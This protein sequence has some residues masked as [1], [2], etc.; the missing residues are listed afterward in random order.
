MRRRTKYSPDF[1]LS[2]VKEYLSDDSLT[3]ADICE[4][5]SISRSAFLKW[6]KKY[7][8]SGFD[9][10]VFN[11]KKGRPK[12]IISDFSKIPPFIYESAGISKSNSFDSDDSV[13]LKKKIEYYERLILEKEVL[14]KI[15]EDEINFLKKKKQFEKVTFIGHFLL[16]FKYRSYGVSLSFLLNHYSISSSSFYYNNRLFFVIGKSKR[17]PHFKGFSFSTLEFILVILKH[18]FA[19]V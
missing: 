12:N 19:M 10:N 18:R 3:Q 1:K 4:K 17:I 7:E 14:L 6:V 8:D 9:D 5:Y 13:A 11:S 16:V 15:Q 2:V